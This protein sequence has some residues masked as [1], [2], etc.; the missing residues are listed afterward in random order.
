MTCFAAPFPMRFGE[1]RREPEMKRRMCA[2]TS[3]V[4]PL[5]LEEPRRRSARPSWRW[6]AACGHDL[7]GVEF[8]QEDHR[9]ASH[10]QRVDRHEQAVRVVDRQRAWI[11]VPSVNRQHSTS[12]RALDADSPA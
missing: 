9:S 3:F 8:R 11:N 10:Q 6:R 12:A 1:Q 7:V 4:R 5:V 2:V